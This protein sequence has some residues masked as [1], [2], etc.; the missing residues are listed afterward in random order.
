LCFSLT[1]G[2]LNRI[3][4]W[5]FV[6]PKESIL[7]NIWL[8]WHS[9]TFQIDK[10]LT[11]MIWMTMENDKLYLIEQF[12]MMHISFCYCKSRVLQEIHSEVQFFQSSPLKSMQ[13]N[14][15]M[16]HFFTSKKCRN[17]LLWQ[18]YGTLSYSW[19]LQCDNLCNFGNIRHLLQSFVWSGKSKHLKNHLILLQNRSHSIGTYTQYKQ[20]RCSTCIYLIWI[21]FDLL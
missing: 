10:V 3:V 9:M 19:C 1:F 14:R 13:K 20:F 16:V 5:M 8:V 18:P 11:G 21:S 2:F 7:F 6:D 15:Y 4:S 12:D 17:H